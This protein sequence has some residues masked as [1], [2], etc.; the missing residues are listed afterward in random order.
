MLLILMLF[1]NEFGKKFETD[2]SSG[3]SESLNKPDEKHQ[4]LEHKGNLKLQYCF[5]YSIT[6]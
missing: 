1:Q 3:L 6:V 4:R 2:S 5:L